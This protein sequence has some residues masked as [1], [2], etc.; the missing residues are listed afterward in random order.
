M[1]Y[2]SRASYVLSSVTISERAVT[3][4]VQ[5]QPGAGNAEMIRANLL[6]ASASFTSSSE[7]KPQCSY[8]FVTGCSLAMFTSYM[9][10]SNL[11]TQ[12]LT[13]MIIA[14]IPISGPAH[15]NAD[16]NPA[17]RK[18]PQPA[19][20]LVRHSN[21]FVPERMVTHR[22]SSNM[23][24][25]SRCTPSP[26]ALLAEM[27][28][29]VIANDCVVLAHPGWNSPRPLSCRE[30]AVPTSGERRDAITPHRMMVT[31]RS[32]RSLSFRASCVLHSIA[33]TMP[34]QCSNARRAGY[35]PHFTHG[36]PAP[37]NANNTKYSGKISIGYPRGAQN[38]Y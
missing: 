21:C 9:F 26:T 35:V 30:S 4:N 32:L 24:A 17:N 28:S 36:T 10:I 15:T 38:D 14:I 7:T 1:R 12:S 33:N 29:D 8:R 18:E 23:H 19:N 6:R 22:K 3:R 27:S 13:P 20:L 25:Q 37:I 2:A 11:P 5:P 31:H 16:R 34:S